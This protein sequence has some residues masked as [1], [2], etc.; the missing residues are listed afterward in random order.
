MGGR[1]A[2]ECRKT[3]TL[4]GEEA[5]EKDQKDKKGEKSWVPHL[6]VL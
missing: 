4:G 5:K 1:W 2:N 3:W 6:I